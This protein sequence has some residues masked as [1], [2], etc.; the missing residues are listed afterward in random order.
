MAHEKKKL[1]KNALA[2]SKIFGRKEQRA[3]T[4]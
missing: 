2:A 1:S 3:L 4:I